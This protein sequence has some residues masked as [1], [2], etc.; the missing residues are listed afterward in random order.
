MLASS[1]EMGRPKGDQGELL[2]SGKS[3]QHKDR[4]AIIAP[5]LT[6]LPKG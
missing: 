3:C 6:R 5:L 4:H 1:L 2:S